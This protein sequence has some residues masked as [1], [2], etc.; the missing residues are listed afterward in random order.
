MW[1]PIEAKIRDYSVSFIVLDMY[2]VIVVWDTG[3]TGSFYKGG[4]DPAQGVLAFQQD[5][6]GS[7]V[8]SRGEPEGNMCCYTVL[9]T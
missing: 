5:L 6:Q 1:E 7:W 3:D 4:G 8:L 9:R 2:A